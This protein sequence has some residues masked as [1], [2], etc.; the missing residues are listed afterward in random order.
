[1]TLN[2]LWFLELSFIPIGSQFGEENTVIAYCA[3]T[4]IIVIIIIML[5]II[6]IN[7]NN[8]NNNNNKLLTQNDK[9]APTPDDNRCSH[10]I[11]HANNHKEGN[12]FLST[13]VNSMNN[14][15]LFKSTVPLIFL[16]HS[17]FSWFW[18]HVPVFENFGRIKGMLYF[19]LKPLCISK[20]LHESVCMEVIN[21]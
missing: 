12:A 16:Q 4:I 21:V 20:S 1:M 15:F 2:D 6:I 9:P 18:C 8:N 3:H 5:T 11:F 13:K 17:F 7:N 14:S 19:L 10:R